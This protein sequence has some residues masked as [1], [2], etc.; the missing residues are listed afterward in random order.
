MW[1][2]PYRVTVN[3]TPAP[4][5]RASQ[6]IARGAEAD[7]A[8]GCGA[9]GS[10]AEVVGPV[11]ADLP[12]ST[13][14][15]LEDVRPGAGGQR[16]RAAGFVGGEG[17]RLLDEVRPPGSRGRGLADHRSE[18]ASDVAA[19]V[20]GDPAGGEL[21][22][23]V[24]GRGGLP[25]PV[26]RDPACVP[27]GAA[28]KA[29]AQPGAGP[30]AARRLRGREGR[31]E[32]GSA[33]GGRQPLRSDPRGRWAPIGRR[34]RAGAPPAAGWPQ[35]GGRRPRSEREERTPSQTAINAVAN[36]EPPRLRARGFGASAARWVIR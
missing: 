36:A 9:A 4:M 29:N 5:R 11:D 13:L 2:W 32:R 14:E 20:D 27:V 25:R 21:D 1:D 3:G 10:A 23:Q 8:V 19:A 22:P 35:P 28:G 18:L 12:R 30:G 31:C 17:Q 33:A 24:P 16:E 34:D 26:R 7:A 6:V 15:F